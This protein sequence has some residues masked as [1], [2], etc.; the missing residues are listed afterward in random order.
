MVQFKFNLN[1]QFITYSFF[2]SFRI[3][4]IWVI[5]SFLS[6]LHA[7]T[8]T[9]LAAATIQLN[10][11]AQLPK[12]FGLE[13]SPQGVH[14]CARPVHSSRSPCIKSSQSQL[15]RWQLT[16]D[17]P[18]SLSLQLGKSKSTSHPNTISPSGTQR[19]NGSTVITRAMVNSQVLVLT[20][21]GSEYSRI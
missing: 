14:S 1:Y 7:S 20:L 19:C 15:Q 12:I 10:R 2:F 3:V 18:S 4:C 8:Q 11:P 16:A 9:Y 6:F 17:P 13:P 5:S 21:R